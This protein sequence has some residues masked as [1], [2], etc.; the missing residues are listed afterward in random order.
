MDD[1]GQL[2]TQHI[3]GEF[4]EYQSYRRDR[5]IGRVSH[6]SLVTG[7]NLKPRSVCAVLSSCELSELWT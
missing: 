3:P 2:I 7:S 5:C 6:G 4:D 1:S